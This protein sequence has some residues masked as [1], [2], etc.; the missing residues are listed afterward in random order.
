MKSM[1]ATCLL[2]ILMLAGVSINRA[3]LHRVADHMT[4]TL[5]ALPDA[6]DDACT[7]AVGRLSDYWQKQVPWVGISVSFPQVDR[8]SEQ[9]ALLTAAAEC[10]DLYGYRAAIALLQDAIGDMSRLEK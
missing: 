4:S 7:E 10:Q 2:L 5:V 6:G 1:I 3:Y 8:V 9:V